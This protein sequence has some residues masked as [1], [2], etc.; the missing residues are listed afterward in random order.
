MT[1]NAVA[2]WAY[3]VRPPQH[4]WQDWA[5]GARFSRLL[6]H[7]VAFESRGQNC[8]VVLAGGRCSLWLAPRRFS[9]TSPREGRT[10]RPTMKAARPLR[11]LDAKGNPAEPELWLR[12]SERITQAS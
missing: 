2:F 12:T 3:C 4:G 9:Q 11:H 6:L 8:W 1:V 7:L 5:A 10:C